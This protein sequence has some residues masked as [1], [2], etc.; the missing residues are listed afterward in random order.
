MVFARKS[1]SVGF[2]LIELLVVIAIIAVLIGMLLPALGK[3]RKSARQTIS[4]SN[5]RS[6][7]QSAAA[8]QNDQKGLLPLSPTWQSRFGPTNPS[9]LDTNLVGLCTWSAWG[10][11]NSGAW[12]TVDPRF[13][14]K[15]EDRPLNAY[16]YPNLV[17][18]PNGRA[19]TA[20]DRD[21]TERS[22]LA[23]PVFKD[24]SDSNGH[25][26]DWPN[27]NPL[28]RGEVLSCYADVGTSYQ[29]QAKW[30]EQIDNDPQFRNKPYAEKFSIG[31]RRFRLADNF[32]PSRLVWLNDEWADIVMN[33]QSAT[34]VVKNGYD[35]INK[36]VMGFLDTHVA[37][38]SVL[39][40]LPTT[41]PN[42]NYEL[43]AQ[44][45]NDK[46]TVIFPYSR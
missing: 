42:N 33:Q 24:P 39:P 32:S 18:I 35:D 36:S 40:G 22:Q 4:L 44:Y 8:Y 41:I 17:G 15:A 29:W 20:P 27:P 14:V 19:G 16:I 46:Y 5:V 37:Y 11:T 25:Q 9:N 13:D 2:T 6:I 45:N 28:Y 1:R 10:R 34:A 12:L 26:Q 30:F 21:S 43:V 23:M 38:L 31:A 3:A 7:G